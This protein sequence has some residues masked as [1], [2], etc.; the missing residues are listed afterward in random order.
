MS[1]ALTTFEQLD[2]ASDWCVGQQKL[3]LAA[4]GA[5]RLDAAVRHIGLAVDG[6]VDQTPLQRVR[7]HTARSHILLSDAASQAE[8]K[9]L[10]NQTERVAIQ[11]RL[12]H[13]IHAIRVIRTSIE[14]YTA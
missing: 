3:A 12:G 1:A 5:G 9:R 2:E 10:L 8:G 13:Q 6:M 4:R 14:E 7:L 11:H